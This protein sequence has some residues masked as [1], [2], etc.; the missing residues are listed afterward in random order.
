[1]AF[2]TGVSLLSVEGSIFELTVGSIS[3]TT[4]LVYGNTYSDTW[5]TTVNSVAR[6]NDGYGTLADITA[7]PMVTLV[8][9]DLPTILPT[10][11]SAV[12]SPSNQCRFL[13]TAMVSGEASISTIYP[14]IVA[15][16]TTDQYRVRNG[17]PVTVF[18]NYTIPTVS[19]T[20][21]TLSENSERKTVTYSMAYNQVI[22]T[23]IMNAIGGSVTGSTDFTPSF[24]V[25]DFDTMTCDFY[26]NPDK[27]G[28]YNN[29]VQIRCQDNY[30]IY[31]N[32]GSSFTVSATRNLQWY[33]ATSRT[34]NGNGV[35]VKFTADGS[36]IYTI[37]GTEPDRGGDDTYS[38]WIGNGRVFD[39]L[40]TIG[41]G[42]F[43]STI[44]YYQ[45]KVANVSGNTSWTFSRVGGYD[46]GWVVLN[47]D[48]W[49]DM[50]YNSSYP[51][52]IIHLTSNDVNG[53]YT[54]VVNVQI[55]NYANTVSYS[56]NVTLTLTDS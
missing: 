30:G 22:G 9:G 10:F 46:A 32:Y 31:S 16:T 28:T 11:D 38:S 14:E 20:T 25:V 47:K 45:I 13:F 36:L 53:V 6:Q 52:F 8:Y 19:Y 21:T 17:N 18:L 2:S 24:N 40:D 55:R 42:F 15:W 4:A 1:M 34:V 56:Q 37:N 51:N 41:N 48:Q 29:T 33:A 27:L 39:I 26:L 49:Y 44:P 54:G 50:N 43:P 7:D 35:G 5:S 12:T 3:P 23:P